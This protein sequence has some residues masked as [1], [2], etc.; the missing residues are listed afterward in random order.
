MDEARA[1][2]ETN[3]KRNSG[4]SYRKPGDTDGEVLCYEPEVESASSS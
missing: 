2:R 3:D 4:G 1:Q